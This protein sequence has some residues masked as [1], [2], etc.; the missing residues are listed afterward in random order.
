MPQVSVHSNP[1]GGYLV[2]GTDLDE[3]SLS[4]QLCYSGNKNQLVFYSYFMFNLKEKFTDI[5]LLLI[6]V[7]ENFNFTCIVSEIQ[8]Q[9]ITEPVH[10]LMKDL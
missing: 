3:N 2:H 9:T 4:H 5:E 6:P 10:A 1:G 7:K 8:L